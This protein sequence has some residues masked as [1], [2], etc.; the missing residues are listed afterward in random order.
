MNRV[1]FGSAAS[2]ILILSSYGQSSRATISGIVTDPQGFAVPGAAVA[3]ADIATGVRT[4]AT[5]NESGFYSIPNLLIGGYNFTV[6]RSG[7]KRYIREG[8]TLT[9]GQTL[10]LDVKLELGAVGESIDV[11]GDAPLTETRT[12]TV[13]QLLDS[14]SVADIPLADR[15]TMNIMNLTA[16]AIF[17][18]YDVN[19]KPSFSVSGGRTEN[20]MFWIDGAGGQNIRIG[21]MN[22]DMD[23]PIDA[24]SEIKVLSNNYSAE[25]GGTPSGVIVTTTKSGTNQLHGSVFEYLR[26]N[27]FDAPGFFAPVQNG[28]KVSPE[29]RYNV[30][31]GTVG[32]PIRKNKTFFFFAYQGQRRNTGAVST[33][34]VPTALQDSGNFSQTFN[35]AGSVIPVYDPATNTTVNGKATRQVF[36]GNII[37]VSRFDP[38]A[39][40]ALQYY[41]APNRAPV[42]IT[43]ANNFV[44]NYVTAL[45]GDFYET[46]IDHN[47]ND[48]NRVTGRYLYNSGNNATSSVYPDPAADPLDFALQHENNFYV[49]WNRIVTPNAVNDMR[50]SFDRRYYHNEPHG[51]DQ[52]YA[53]KLGLSG[54]ADVAFPNFAVSGFSALGNASQER[55][56]QPIDQTEFVDDYSWVRGKH[57]MK[58]GFEAH[59]SLDHEQTLSSPSGSFSF[60]TLSTGLPGNAA[61][62][63]ALASLVL[64]VPNSFSQIVTPILDRHSWYYAAFAQDDWTVSSHL[65]LNL[66]VRWEADTPMADS[67][68]QMNGF[69]LNQINPVSGT[70]GVVK[71]MGVNGFRSNAYNP[72]WKNFAPRF[73]FAWKPFSSAATVIRGG[74]GLVYTA[75]F[76]AADPAL[77]T[78]GFGQSVTINSPDNGLTFP[79]TLRTFT[80][81]TPVSPQLN[82][83]YGAVPLG[84]TPNTTPT[85]FDPS[86]R[87]GYAYQFNLGVQR[88]LPGDMVVEA[89]MLSNDGRRLPNG[90]LPIDQ[91]QPQILGPT[92]DSQADRPF[93]QFSGVTIL[94]P[95]IGTSNYYAG[96][97]RISKRF[98]HGLNFNASFT[99]SKFLDNTFEGGGGTAGADN[100]PYSNYYNRRADYGYSGNDIPNRFVFSAVYELPF[101]KGKPW[102]SKGIGNSIAGGWVLSNVTTAQS[103]PPLTAITQVNTT[104]SFSAGS[105]RPNVLSDPKLNNPSVTEWFN[106]AAFAQPAA[107]TFGNEGVGIIRAPGTVNSDLSLQR[108]FLIREKFQFQ[109]RGEFFNAFNHT[110]LG[111]PGSTFGTA[112]FG[113][114]SSAGAAR[115]IEIG[116]RLSF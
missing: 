84:G 97:V 96:M 98:S 72:D 95:A 11:K 17:L 7:F 102:L 85:F 111:L 5:T 42:N 100:G 78:L 81:Q 115:Q 3:A 19:A 44:A 106:T 94:S 14:K 64:G 4:P 41:P 27:E 48:S 8:V 26:N 71:F 80:A 22:M 91:I 93:P 57:A 15:R 34:T 38:V 39:V 21:T 23:P 112:T 101:G 108:N 70:P 66:G 37:P 86:R 54:L 116:V 10:G 55:L 103:G 32:G 92:H 61:T 50:F 65:T 99:R 113:V 35:A 2:A 104:N 53:A 6:E 51:L 30:F 25:Y 24:V 110:N 77:A 56:Q 45:T 9:T 74:F 43:G 28:A 62:G 46:K 107:F 1:L 16:G 68:N 60:S 76:D 89:S 49:N 82:D 58:F 47:F 40:K 109:F 52:G 90:N 88:E 31:G 69:D 105:L 83:S 59:R 18:G 29:L 13:D 79:F 33:L 75:P 73:G 114:V 63:S 36:A 12:S 87:T 20:Q 67:N